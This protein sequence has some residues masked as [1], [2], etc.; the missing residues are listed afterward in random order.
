MTNRTHPT[1]DELQRW[2]TSAGDTRTGVHVDECEQCQSELEEISGLDDELLAD[3]ATV[4]SVPAGLERRT[5]LRVE[6]RLRDEEAI[7]VLVDLFGLG[8]S[9]FRVMTDVEGEG[10]D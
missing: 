9:M 8:W 10:R 4:L 2:L 7:G 5:A 6:Q 3:L 1:G